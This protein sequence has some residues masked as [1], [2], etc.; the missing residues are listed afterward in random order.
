MER[1]A[2]GLEAKTLGEVEHLD[3]HL[4][5][6]AELARQRPFGA[7]AGH[8]DAAE[9][10]RAGG[11]LRQLLQFGLG[12][13]GEQGN[14]LAMGIGDVALLLDGVAERDAIGRGA[15]LQ[16]KIDFTGAGDVEVG[17]QPGQ[18]GNDFGCRIGLD[19]VIHLGHRQPA[20]D[21]EIVL[22]DHV[23]IDDQ[24]GGGGLN[25]FQEAGDLGGHGKSSLQT[26]PGYESTARP[27]KAESGPRLD[28]RARQA[29]TGSDGKS[30][31]AVRP[32]WTYFEHRTTAWTSPAVAQVPDRR[33][34]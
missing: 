26:D 23:E 20:S 8:Q 3:R 12:V 18:Q 30:R 14:A 13:E 31:D 21:V 6:A 28:P 29:G 10:P 34:K 4:G 9:H 33:G 1:D 24:A 32:V 15:S 2:A 11:R 27:K 19:G 7:V 16:A 22:S 5:I 25:V 17:A